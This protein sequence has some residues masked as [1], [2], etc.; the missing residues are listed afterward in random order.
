MNQ[1]ITITINFN[2]G[3]RDFMNAETEEEK[4]LWEYLQKDG[5]ALTDFYL[6]FYL[7]TLDDVPGLKN[8]I[9]ALSP[10]TDEDIVYHTI[11]N[12]PQD[13]AAKIRR[14]LKNTNGKFMEQLITKI[15]HQFKEPEVLKTTIDVNQNEP[16]KKTRE[17]K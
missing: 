9:D 17:T 10:R 3:F 7:A 6:N 12:L 2:A 13:T 14:R 15:W 8:H 11:S 16:K 1:N 5:Q 4:K